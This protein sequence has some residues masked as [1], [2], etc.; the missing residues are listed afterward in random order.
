MTWSIAAAMMSALNGAY[1]L[2]KALFGKKDPTAGGIEDANTHA[3]ATMNKIEKTSSEATRDS[4]Q[5]VANEVQT[6]D[7]V[8]ADRHSQL[9][10]AHGLRARAAVLEATRD[11][12]DSAAGSNG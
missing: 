7:D 12:T 9:A 3:V 11:R 6:A 1:N 5:G 4:Q 8:A 2:F 10:A